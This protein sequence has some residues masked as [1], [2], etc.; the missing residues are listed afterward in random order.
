MLDHISYEI[1]NDGTCSY[2]GSIANMVELPD[3][4]IDFNDRC[5]LCDNYNLEIAAENQMYE[6]FPQLTT[7]FLEEG[8]S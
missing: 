6:K 3:G 1:L 2:C 5:D 8:E 7:I 4:D